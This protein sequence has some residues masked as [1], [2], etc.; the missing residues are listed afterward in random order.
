VNRKEQFLPKTTLESFRKKPKI[1]NSFQDI[2][3]GIFLFADYF[4]NQDISLT[5]KAANAILTHVWLA[6]RIFEDPMEVWFFVAG[7]RS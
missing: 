3:R 1:L 2:S 7:E 4:R 5:K 6:T